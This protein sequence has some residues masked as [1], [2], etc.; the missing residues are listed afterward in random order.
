MT[1]RVRVYVAGS[2]AERHER[3]KPV[4]AALREA[5]FTIT[6][7]W[8]QAVDMVSDGAELTEEQWSKCAQDD[9]FGVFEAEVFVFLAPQ[10][11]S[12]GAWVEL[13]FALRR[14]YSTIFI[15]GSADP[16]WERLVDRRFLSDEATVA[17]VIREFG[18]E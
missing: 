17:A 10:K 4:I 2:S 6:H 15:S 8:T 3:A 9:L 13:G 1:R 11:P 16:F 5:G 7:D 18:R 14:S 12:R